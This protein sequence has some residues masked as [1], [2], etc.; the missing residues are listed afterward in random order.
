MEIQPDSVLIQK[1]KVLLADVFS[2][3][4]RAHYFHWN[5]EGHC[6]VMYHDFFGEIYNDAWSSVDDIAEHIRALGA[7]APGTLKRFAEI[8]T[9]EQ[10]S[11]NEIPTT[12]LNMV[13]ILLND[14]IKVLNSLHSVYT[15]ASS[16]L[17]L[18]NY[19]QDRID[20]HEK[21]QWKLKSMSKEC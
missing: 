8:T 2:M 14:N 20:A 4:L 13:R 16:Q 18:A 15:E 19:I 17:G 1:M 11:S 7:Y 9:T 6:F 12:A 10:I 5:V 3:Y 21:L